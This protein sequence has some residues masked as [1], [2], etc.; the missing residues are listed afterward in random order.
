MPSTR[1]LNRRLFVIA[2]A[3]PHIYASRI[4]GD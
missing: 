3:A 2:A 4:I 1:E